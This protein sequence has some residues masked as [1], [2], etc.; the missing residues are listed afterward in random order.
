MNFEIK[1]RYTE[2]VIFIAKIDVSEDCDYG[3][4]LGMAV[5]QAIKQ[6][7]SLRGANL[8]GVNLEGA[9]L[10]DVNL[11]GAN[12]IGAILASVNLKGSDL[13]GAN[14]IG[15]ILRGANLE[16]ANLK[17]SDLRG[18]DITRAYLT[19]AN[20]EPIKKDM[21]EVLSQAIPE[22]PMLK[23]AIIEGKI[24]GSTYEGECACLCGTIEKGGRFG[25]EC[26]MRDSKRPI[27]RFFLGIGVGDTPETNHFS[28]LA[29]EWIEEFERN[30]EKPMKLEYKIKA[31]IDFD[32]IDELTDLKRQ[33]FNH[34]VLISYVQ[35]QNRW[36][37]AVTRFNFNTKRFT[38]T[39]YENRTLLPDNGLSFDS[40]EKAQDSAVNTLNDLIRDV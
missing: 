5:R 33:G 38:Y 18:V 29:L 2:N 39:V 30:M 34:H 13:R 1:N 37:H 19:G 8:E 40:L 28:E 31:L 6:G 22:I 36:N 3:L 35:D 24:D 23:K 17:G 14:L 10:I 21:F 12:L 32:H 26:D 16:G 15:A 4:K 25:D 27:E 9:N 11:G 7:V 20:L